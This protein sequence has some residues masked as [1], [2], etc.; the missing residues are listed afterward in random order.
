MTELKKL[1]E[2]RRIWFFLALIAFIPVLIAHYFFQNYLYMRP[3]EHCVYL[4][5]D[6]L[7][8]AFGA[9]LCFVYPKSKILKVLAFILIF[10]GVFMGI[11]HS[12]ILQKI[13]AMVLEENPFGGIEGCKNIPQ[14]IFNLPLHEWFKGW[15]LPSGECGNDKPFV[16][17]GTILSPLQEFFIGQAPYFQNG[18]YSK[19]W[20]LIPQYSFINMAQFCFLLFLFVGVLSILL[21]LGFVLKIIDKKVL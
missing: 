4:R 8:I 16:L 10:Y 12:L 21:F 20:F 3:C 13:Y 15:F 17:E 9:F 7:F 19:G 18:L 6:M 11:K 2:A 1:Q 5:L 14:F